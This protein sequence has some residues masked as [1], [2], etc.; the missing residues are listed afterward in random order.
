MS[1]YEKEPTLEAGISMGPLI[2]AAFWLVFAVLHSALARQQVQ[3]E[4][5]RQLAGYYRLAY[6]VV[7]VLKLSI[8]YQV[9]RAWLDV[10]HFSLF[11]NSA[12]FYSALFIKYLGIAVMLLAVMMYDIGRFTGITQALTGERVSSSAHEPLQRR[13]LNR[14]VRHPL[15]TGAFLILWGGAI[16]TFDVW[17]AIWGTLYL[18]IGTV[19]E[20]RKLVRIYGE[21]YRRYQRE[22][23]KYFPA[24]SYSKH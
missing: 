21:E 4:L 7:A 11:D 17:T 23:P 16:S 8:V 5:E 2:Y 18:L 6:N 1:N 20:E 15:Y 19:Y 13:F 22:V 12:F 14:W 10:G 3:R 9:G 24:F